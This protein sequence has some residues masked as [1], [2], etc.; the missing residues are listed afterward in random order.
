MFVDDLILGV[1]LRLLVGG[2]VGGR[3]GAGEGGVSGYDEKERDVRR[4]L[5]PNR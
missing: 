5:V 4:R 3:E 2:W 1:D